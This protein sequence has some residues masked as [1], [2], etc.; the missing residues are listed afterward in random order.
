MAGGGSIRMVVQG[1]DACASSLTVGVPQE[2]SSR[3]DAASTAA[4]VVCPNQG[5]GVAGSSTGLGT[6][7]KLALAGSSC[8]DLWWWDG[9]VDAAARKGVR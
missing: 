2:G 4:V 6:G 9:G 5:E 3:R 7:G 1:S 8:T